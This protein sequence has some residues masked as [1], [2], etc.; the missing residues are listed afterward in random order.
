MFGDRG[1]AI[2]EHLASAAFRAINGEFG[3]T[4]VRALEVV[5][6]L[7]DRELAVLGGELW[8]VLDGADGWKGLIPQQQG[9]DAVY[10]WE[11]KKGTGEAW[12]VFVRRCASE[13]LA[14]IEELPRPG[15][16]RPNLPGRIL[17]NLT[18]VSQGGEYDGLLQRRK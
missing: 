13:T 10:A 7:A 4:G 1:I 8:W 14:A 17:Y 9:P 18:W 12:P 2:P 16:L 15:E 6:I 11:T 5:A 3:W